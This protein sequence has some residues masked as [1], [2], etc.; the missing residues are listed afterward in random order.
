MVQLD[1]AARRVPMRNHN[2]QDRF[3]LHIYTSLAVTGY[4]LGIPVRRRIVHGWRFV[5][6]DMIRGM[7]IKNL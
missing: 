2:P 6:C 7:C 3:R 4:Q 1:G 5:V